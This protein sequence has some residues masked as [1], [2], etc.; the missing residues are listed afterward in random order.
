MAGKPSLRSAGVTPTR[1]KTILDRR[2][3]AGTQD[4]CDGGESGC[5]GHRGEDLKMP[6]WTSHGQ[7]CFFRSGWPLKWLGISPSQS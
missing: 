4:S 6:A 2:C 5:H 7:T 3:P 1:G